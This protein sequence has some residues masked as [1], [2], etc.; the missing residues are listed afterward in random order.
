MNNNYATNLESNSDDLIV[1]LSDNELDKTHGG[2]FVAVALAASMADKI[3]Q[4]GAAADRM[5]KG[6]NAA[7]GIDI[8]RAMAGG[9]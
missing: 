3:A 9:R 4:W 1:D 6:D 2:L 5:T 7:S 8:S